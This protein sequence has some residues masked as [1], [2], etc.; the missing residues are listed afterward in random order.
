MNTSTSHTSDTIFY[1]LDQMSRLQYVSLLVRF[2]LSCANSKK[3]NQTIQEYHSIVKIEDKHHF[4]CILTWK[5]WNCKLL[6]CRQTNQY[7]IVIMIEKCFEIKM[8][9][10]SIYPM[11]VNGLRVFDFLFR[12]SFNIHFQSHHMDVVAR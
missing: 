9:R 5:Y 8:V 10:Y 7:P 3:K 1:L 4:Y 12:F 11:V 6:H 2:I